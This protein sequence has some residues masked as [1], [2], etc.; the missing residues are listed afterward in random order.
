MNKTINVQLKKIVD[1]SYKITV[2]SGFLTQ[3]PKML[4]KEHPASSYVIIADSV[5]AKLFGKKL[6]ATLRRAGC[7]SIMLSVPVGESSKSQKQKTALEE[8]ML[9][10]GVDRRGLVLA[11]G[12]G[13]VGDLAGFVAAT[14]MR[15]I[16]YIQLPTTLLAMVDSSL[17]GKT[18]IDTPQGKNLIG[19]FHQPKAV[20]ADLDALESLGERELRN[21]LV[22]AAKMFMTSD[23]ASFV[24][25]EKNLDK[26]LMKN[27]GVLSEI[28]SR[29]AAIKARVVGSDERESGERMVLNF[30]H[31]IGHALEKLSRYRIMHG[32][33]VALGT[34]VEARIAQNRGRLST[35]DYEAIKEILARLDVDCEM[36]RQFKSKHIVKATKGDKK[37][38]GGQARCVILRKIG[39]VEEKDGRFVEAVSDAEVLK[40]LKDVIKT[41]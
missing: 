12:G 27:T 8:T 37:S 29:A 24:F 34:L 4:Q 7:T 3:L 14:Y 6:L 41:L 9:K 28:I 15:G 22:E 16:P 5:T 35:G 2:G 38:I 39:K 40:A 13:V 21:G 33:A 25:L 20:Y 30:G 32:Q 23:A 19:A 31:T 26:A 36:L 11:L 1:T 10:A 18:G 17:G